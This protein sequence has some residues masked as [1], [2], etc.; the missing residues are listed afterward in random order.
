MQLTRI[1]E[2]NLGAELPDAGGYGVW[3]PG[4]FQQ[5]GNFC[6]VSEKN[7]HFNAFW[8]KFHIFL[9]PFEG[10]KLIRFESQL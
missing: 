6:D 9:D 3:G 2:R 7:R 1:T 5:L 4:G 8:I 10:T